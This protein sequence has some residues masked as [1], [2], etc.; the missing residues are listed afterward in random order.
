MMPFEL[1][2]G[3][4]TQ[5]LSWRLHKVRHCVNDFVTLVIL[6]VYSVRARFGH[7][8]TTITGCLLILVINYTRWYL[9]VLSIS[10]F[11]SCRPYL[12]SWCLFFPVWALGSNSRS[13]YN[14]LF[15]FVQVLLYFKGRSFALTRP[16]NIKKIANK[17]MYQKGWNIW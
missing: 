12:I 2:P 14:C 5:A 8:Y 13:K 17:Q 15:A 4:W 6:W 10:S 7:K 11:N 3:F 1:M 16:N 9:E